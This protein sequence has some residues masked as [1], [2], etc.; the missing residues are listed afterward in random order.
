MNCFLYGQGYLQTTT[1][2]FA[3]VT[4]VNRQRHTICL[5]TRNAMFPSLIS[6][7]YKNSCRMDFRWPSLLMSSQAPCIP[8]FFA[9]S[10]FRSVSSMK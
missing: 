1:V 5:P 10:T 9:A 4:L 2:S 6:V 7:V 3:N 8:S